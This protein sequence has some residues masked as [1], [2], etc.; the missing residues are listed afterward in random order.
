MRARWG[1]SASKAA[2]RKRASV[3]N[4]DRGRTE[5]RRGT[6]ELAGGQAGDAE[7]GA[8]GRVLEKESLPKGTRE[9]YR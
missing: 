2:S 5:N 6:W 4:G 3:E 1:E 8:R 9:V 7:R